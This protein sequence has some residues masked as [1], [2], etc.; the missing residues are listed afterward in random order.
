MLKEA[1]KKGQKNQQSV[2]EVIEKKKK[3]YYAYNMN[4][5]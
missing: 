4:D 1:T 3:I 5:F 2:E